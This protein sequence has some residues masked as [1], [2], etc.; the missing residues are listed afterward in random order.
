MDLYFNISILSPFLHRYNNLNNA[1]ISRG[2]MLHAAVHS[3]QSFDRH[4]D[5]VRMLIFCY[6][7]FSIGR[8]LQ[9]LV[10]E[11]PFPLKKEEKKPFN[12]NEKPKLSSSSVLG[13]AKRGRVF[14]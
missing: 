11:V 10:Q 4:L 1:V 14:V 5:Q 9:L 13:V 6:L 8:S 12:I 3:L 7:F 2:K